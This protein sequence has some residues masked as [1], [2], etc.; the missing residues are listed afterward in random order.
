MAR[1]HPVRAGPL[2]H[3]ELREV[4]GA[5]GDSRVDILDDRVGDFDAD[6][7][8]RLLSRAANVRRE[9]HILEATEGR[10]EVALAV[11]LWLLGEDVG[12]AAREV[13]RLDGVREGVD[14]DNVAAGEVDEEGAL[15]RRISKVGYGKNGL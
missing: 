14:V 6:G 7:L 9:D 10:L 3:V 1:E 11:A 2:R 13:A 15:T 4:D 12:A 5:V 8:L